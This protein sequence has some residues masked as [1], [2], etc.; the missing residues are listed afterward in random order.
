VPIVTPS[1]EADPPEPKVV[2]KADW[3]A[4]PAR[5]DPLDG[6]SQSS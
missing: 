2:P 5:P 6:A 4:A 3:F 1:Y